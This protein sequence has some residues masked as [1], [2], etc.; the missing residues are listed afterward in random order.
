MKKSI[1]AL[2]L[3]T[4]SFGALANG[5][6]DGALPIAEFYKG[7]DIKSI[8][9]DKVQSWPY[10]TYTSMNLADYMVFGVSQ[11]SAASSPAVLT[12]ATNQFDLGSEFKDGQSYIENLVSTQ[13][14]GFIVM[15]G[16]KIIADFY[17][18]GYA[19]G[20]INN[21]QSAA[22][23]YVG[24]IVSQ[25]VDEGKLDLDATVKSYLPG[26]KGSVIGDATLRQV[27]VMGSG[28]EA[29]HDYHTPGS[30]GY[31][32]EVEYGL[33]PNGTPIGHFKA[34]KASKASANPIGEAWDYSDVNTDTLTLIAEKVSG[35]SYPV[36][37]S[38]LANK[39]GSHYGSEIVNTSDGTS[40]SAFGI[41]VSA[42][43]FALFH[44]YIA[45]GKAGKTYYKTVKDSSMDT[46]SMSEIGK[47]ISGPN[48]PLQY[49]M[50]SYYLAEHDIIVS[51]G[52]F[53]QFGLSDPQTGASVINQ[54][55]WS[56]NANTDKTADT[57]E[58]SVK[59]LK[60]LR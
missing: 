11:V 3:A 43:D 10:M 50:Q 54:S 12:R 35:K 13:T 42:I 49:G 2:I 45:E 33:Q 46:L 7:Y 20:K 22:K 37:L 36:L 34:I 23:S 59:I 28:V 58:R 44:Q 60:S 8:P 29:L 27:S 18:N 56:I 32:W 41:N 25:L 31:L 9:Q 47:A 14:K 38:E 19:Q 15:Q 51:F 40:A 26:L 48:G 30:N 1:L 21:L 6:T 39:I 5:V 17:D 55:D 4:S 24:V 52:S 16:N 57:L 53:G